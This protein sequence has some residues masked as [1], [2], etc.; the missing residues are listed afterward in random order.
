LSRRIA[1]LR[2]R[3]EVLIS[4]SA[5][6]IYGDRGDEQ[7]T[8]ESPIGDP[9]Q[10]FLVSVCRDW[11]AAAEPARQAGVRVM[12]PRFSVVLGTAGGALSRLLPIFKSGLAGKI[13]AGTQWMSWIAIDDA[14]A[15]L[16]RALDDAALQGPVN[17]TSPQ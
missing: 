12:H 7:L 11:E 8:E 16:V 1:E 3:P 5:M 9:R 13:G 14:V 15:I 10:D 6:G 17:V 2:P 4:A